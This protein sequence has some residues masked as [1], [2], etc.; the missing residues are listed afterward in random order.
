MINK[1]KI[2]C[3]GNE[4]CI[5]GKATNQAYPCTYEYKGKIRIIT[6]HGRYQEITANDANPP[7]ALLLNFSKTVMSHDYS[8]E[9]DKELQTQDDLNTQKVVELFWKNNPLTIVNGK[10]HSNTKVADQ[11]NIIDVG[12]KTITSVNRF[13]DIMRAANKINEM[14]HLER[15]D[16]AFY[17]GQ[18]PI[19]KSE[20]E[21]LVYL[22]DTS[23]G[24]CLS[25]E[26][27]DGFL[28]VWVDG[29]TEDRE[30]LIVIKKAI[31]YNIID[32]RSIDGRNNYYLNESF[33]GVDEN[34]MIDWCR[35]S[36]RDYNEH[37]VRVVLETD[38][39]NAKP[40]KSTI[41]KNI[42]D[43][44]EFDSL[45]RHAKELKEEGF[46]DDKVSYQS[47]G[48]GKLSEVVAAAIE[49]KNSVSV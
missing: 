38:K 36:P 3:K 21:L 13:K 12:T 48:F 11:Y 32:N 40:E 33:M 42:V 28:R 8:Y 45:K 35:K 46:I 39:S 20:D 4:D 49:K 14:T 43:L 18:S 22:A 37:I 19:G 25:I 31:V 27:L 44:N 10:I 6:E 9:T 2:A 5:V 1:V 24:L 47:M 15:C 41:S 26:N 29:K 23:T 17:Y 7:K 34:G 30:M 16:V